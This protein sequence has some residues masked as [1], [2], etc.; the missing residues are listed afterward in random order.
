MK[1]KCKTHFLNKQELRRNK[2]AKVTE[3]IIIIRGI[4]DFLHL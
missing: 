1:G 3:K 4:K 2:I